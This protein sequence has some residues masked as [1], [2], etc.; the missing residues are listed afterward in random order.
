MRNVGL[1]GSHNKAHDLSTG[2]NNDKNLSLYCLL[3][4]PCKEMFA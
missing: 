1:N 4:K 2:G 3:F